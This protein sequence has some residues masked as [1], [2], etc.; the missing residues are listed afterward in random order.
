[1]KKPTALMLGTALYAANALLGIT[2]NISTDNV[3]THQQVYLNVGVS[4]AYADEAVKYT[5][6]MHHQIISGKP[7]KCPICGMD[8][9]PIEGT[10]EHGMKGEAPVVSIMA[11]TIQKMGVRTEKA[12]KSAIVQG[13]RTTGIV[14][15]NERSR[16][17]LFSQVEGRI[18]DL[19]YSAEGDHV[20]K[21]EL[22]YTLVSPELTALQSDYIA[23]LS[24][25][26]KDI[27]NAAR[28]RMKLLGVDDKVLNTLAKTRKPYDKVPFTIPADGI[29]TK[30]EVH[31]GSYIK[32]GDAVGRI[33]DL[34]VVWV[35]ADV[36]EKDVNSIKTGDM[37]KVS[38]S[39]NSQSYDAKVDY[40]YPTINAEARIAKVRLVV[41]N[42]DG[43]L[44]PA[45][46]A[47]VNFSTGVAEER[48]TVPS[49]AILRDADGAHVI[50]ALGNG[51]FQAQKVKTGTVNSGRT[52][53]LS[54]ISEG[55][56]VVTSSQ[57]MI[58][59]ES[60]LQESLQNLSMPD[61]PGMNM[62]DKP[63]NKG[64]DM[65]SMEMNHE[66]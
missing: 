20:K 13:I 63:D 5:C 39:D 66:K 29:L 10:H 28:K 19:H 51:K 53:I 47:T 37:A 18:E 34:S 60:N 41:D 38:F 55:E 11:E 1:M 23:A 35:D 61:M 54:G 57:F 65:N 50:I 56:I 36:A 43:M 6:P 31:D 16:V 64:S 3:G 59:S 49:E 15:E 8:L 12:Q 40:I 2:A 52:E 17:D 58:D 48:L 45:S 46:Y 32:A 26:L 14:T 42:K 33:Q 4:N 7:G 27:A 30:L 62:Q 9:V 24:G 22:F 25:G 21:G 44:K